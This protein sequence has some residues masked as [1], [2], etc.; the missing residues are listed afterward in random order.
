MVVSSV[1]IFI[2]SNFFTELWGHEMPEKGGHIMF[3]AAVL[4]IAITQ[5]AALFIFLYNDY[6]KFTNLK[7]IRKSFKGVEC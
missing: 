5:F 7:C 4:L 2:V 1:L 3:F 6:Y